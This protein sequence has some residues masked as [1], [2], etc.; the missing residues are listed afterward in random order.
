MW[1][2][3]FLCIGKIA[4]TLS[5]TLTQKW[6][7]KQLPEFQLCLLSLRFFLASS[8]KTD[9]T[10]GKIKFCQKHVGMFLQTWCVLNLGALKMQFVF[11]NCLRL[12]LAFMQ[13]CGNSLRKNL[14]ML[15]QNLKLQSIKTFYFKIN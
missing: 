12:G 4:I 1:P 13:G 8:A 7:N 6:F 11:L 15:S 14:Y 10:V 5:E 9:M 2:Y 3:V